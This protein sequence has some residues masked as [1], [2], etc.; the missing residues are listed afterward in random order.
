MKMVAVLMLLLVMTGCAAVWGKPYKVEFQ[1]S[2]SITINFD[3]ALTNMG[4]VQNVA[5]QHCDQYKKD[6][7]PQGERTSPWGLT[8]ISFNCVNRT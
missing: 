6:A 4:E 7:L 3:P 5:Q 8:N 2:S 1:S